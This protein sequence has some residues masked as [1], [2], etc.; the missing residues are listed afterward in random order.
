MAK[1]IF[2]IV[3]CL[4]LICVSIYI[5]RIFL[6]IPLP[7]PTVPKHLPDENNR[8]YTNNNTFSA[9]APDGWYCRLS[10]DFIRFDTINNDSPIV[11]SFAIIFIVKDSELNQKGT[12]MARQILDDEKLNIVNKLQIFGTDDVKR[13][14]FQGYPALQII[15]EI[16]PNLDEK[17]SYSYMLCFIRDQ[18]LF[19]INYFTTKRVSQKP[20]TQILDYFDTFRI[21]IAAV[22]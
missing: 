6:L 2:N 8:K 7:L 21:E 17:Y 5:L 10:D 15:R 1:R 3:S 19:S 14:T 18:Q 20:P 22:P 9:I 16:Q 4:I 11:Q 13:I 12:D